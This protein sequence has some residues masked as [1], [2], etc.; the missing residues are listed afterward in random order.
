[1]DEAS[2]VVHVEI[3]VLALWSKIKTGFGFAKAEPVFQKKTSL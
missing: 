2:L 1:M 3:T